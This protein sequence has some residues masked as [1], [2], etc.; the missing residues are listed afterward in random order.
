V[1]KS[2]PIILH[3][4]PISHFCEKVR[5]ALHLK[6]LQFQVHNHLPLLHVLTV[7]RLS[8]QQMVPV[9][10]M[11][12]R[13]IPDSNAILHFLD[14]TYTRAPLYPADRRARHAMDVFIQKMDV[15]VGVHI[16]RFFYNSI[17]PDKK[18]FCSLL[19]G[20]DYTR[21]EQAGFRALAPVTILFMRKGMK[22]TPVTAE[23]SRQ[24]LIESLNFLDRKIGRKKYFF[25]KSL[26]AADITVAA[27]LS[28]LV[29]PDEHPMDWPKKM[30]DALRAFRNENID[31]PVCK[32]V[33]KFYAENCR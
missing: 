10:Q 32:W 29:Q 33:K 15:A 25:G 28:P 14:E 13:I 31:R 12:G 23:R 16:R 19:G 30:P 21:G 4:F 6:G 3:Q 27:L 22:I 18:L 1:A 11:R 7:R 5:L 8:G 2:E 20:A 24:R 9:L 17:L 26:S